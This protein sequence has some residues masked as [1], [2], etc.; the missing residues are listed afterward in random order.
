[1]ALTVGLV[2]VALEDGGMVG[3]MG[4]V[5]VDVVVVLVVTT[6]AVPWCWE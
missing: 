2:V 4:L 1:M 6:V 3:V 5:V